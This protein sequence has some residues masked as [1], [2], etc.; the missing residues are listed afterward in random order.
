MQIQ[1][2][3]YILLRFPFLTE[4]FV[5]DE[6]R[7][8]Q[9]QGVRVHLF[10]LL[11]PRNQP[12]Q[13][14]SKDLGEETRYAPELY[15]WRLWRAQ[16]YFLFG[17]PRVYFG[18]LFQLVRQPRRQAF[19]RVF[20]QRVLVF[21]KAVSIAFEL[22]HTDVQIIHAHF[23][24]LSGAAAMVISRLL[25]IPF[26]VTV[27]AY[28]IYASN[29]LLDLVVRSASKVIAISEYNKNQVLALCPGVNQDRITIIHCGI[30]LD[31]FSPPAERHPQNG[32]V[33][34]LS[35]GSLID[36]KGHS[37]LI[38][39]CKRLVSIGLELQ[40]TIIGSGPDEARLRQ[41]IVESGLE[42]RVVLA[43]PRRREEVLEA[44]RHNDLFVLASQISEGG[45]R[46]G[47]PVVLME[48]LAMRLPA[49]STRVSGIPELVRPG[50]TGW[51]VP[52]RDANALA[53]TM[54]AVA[55][56]SEMGAHWACNGRTLVE[57]EFEIKK[58]AS[59]LIQVFQAVA[60]NSQ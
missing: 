56:Q 29:D 59:R 9:K 13:P 47:I 22:R 54:L 8:V 49:I 34:I 42:D 38:Q 44:Y 57:R 39:A 21:F 53:D 28:D 10:S 30:D 16:L 51:L 20:L 26:T 25:A 12:K 11:R 48:A 45:D 50:E 32:A 3:A 2:V 35:I 36:K 24:W 55:R 19:L 6:I 40:C 7:Q 1:N 31:L 5:A 15:S 52:E 41:E 23:A 27:H 58:N 46:D 4:T 18:S 60:E 33:R 37:I 14:G 43:G 17:S